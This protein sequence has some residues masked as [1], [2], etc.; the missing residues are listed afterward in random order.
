MYACIKS[1]SMQFIWRLVFRTFVSKSQNEHAVI[2]GS[3]SLISIGD[4]INNRRQMQ[5]TGSLSQTG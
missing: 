5:P 3:A 4:N 2:R 1:G